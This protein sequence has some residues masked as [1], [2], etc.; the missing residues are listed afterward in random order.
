MSAQR[1]RGLYAI[2]HSPLH[3][4][5]QGL[6]EDVE[7]ALQGGAAVIQYRDKSLD[8]SRRLQEARALASLCH[9]YGVP[10]VVND[11]ARLAADSGAQGV[12]L[13]QGD[14]SLDEARALLGRGAL[15][16]ISC[17]N[18]LDL[19]L[20]AYHQGADYLAL[21]AFF[22][23]PT[24]PRAP[25]ASLE[26]LAEV[27]RSV[28]LPVVAIGGIKADNASALIAQGAALVAVIH[29]VFGQPDIRASASALAQLFAQGSR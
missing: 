8:R 24:K 15:I 16:G 4:G 13:G 28:P 18:R 26:L 10:L 14:A 7:A 22:S 2:T 6:L 23:S 21:G 3:Q 12:H 19:A 20:A 11:D 27:S 5:L 9:G 1:L 17:Y 29:G 25:R